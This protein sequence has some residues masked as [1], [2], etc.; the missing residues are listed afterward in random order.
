[1][2]P[3][4]QQDNGATRQELEG[5]LQTA[6]TGEKKKNIFCALDHLQVRKIH[7]LLSSSE[8]RSMAL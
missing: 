6:E 4:F 1:M 7:M 8:T 5:L 3:L 2:R